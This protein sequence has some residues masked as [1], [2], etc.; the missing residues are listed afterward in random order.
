MSNIS[1]PKIAAWIL[2]RMIDP[3][4]RYSAAG[5]FEERFN[6]IAEERG[7]LRARLFYWSQILILFPSFFNNQIYW[8]AEM[9][10]NYFKIAIRNIVKHKVYSFINIFGLAIGM[11]CCI[12]IILFV[13]EEL[14]FDRYHEN[15][16]QLYRIASQRTQPLD[17][18]PTTRSHYNIAPNLIN[19]FPE[20]EDAVRLIKHNGFVVS[21][22]D[23]RLIINPLYADP[24]LLEVFTFPL[25]RGD[26]KTALQDPNSVVI[27]EE[28][29]ERIFGVKNPMGEILAIHSL[30]S[31]YDL[32]VTG[33]LKNVPYNS[34]FTFNFL[35]PME[36]LRSRYEN[37]RYPSCTTYLLLNENV[38]P[39]EFEKKMP[40][41]VEKYLGER[42]ASAFKYFLQPLTSIHLN[43]E[44]ALEIGQNSDISNSYKLSAVALVVLL[45]ACFNFMN[46]ST[47]RSSQ[48]L[49]EVGVRK[50]VGAARGQI[51]RQFLGE[52]IFLSFIAL[53]FA[54]IL[55]SLFLQFFNSIM[56]RHLTMDFTEN[57]L[58]YAGLASLALIVGFFSGAYPAVFLS[59]F[60]PMDVLKR[61]VKKGTMFGV[62]MRKGLVVFQF[63]A[64]L[65]F[66][67]GTIV[68]FQQLNFISKKDLGFDKS[69][70][71][72]IPVYKDQKFTQRSEWI[73]SEL[74]RNPN[75]LSVI[76]TDDSPGTYG[77]HPTQCSPEGFSDDEFVELNQLIVGEDFFSFFGI[78]IIVGR[79]FSK[80]IAS[81]GDS[82]IILNETA[83]KRLGWTDPIGKQIKSGDSNA[84]RTVIGVVRDFHNASLHKEIRPSIYVYM[85]DWRSC[86]F[87]RVRPNNIQ[88]TIS[89]L[90]KKWLEFPTHLVFKYEFLDDF[91]E[92]S[93]Y[94]DDKKTS[95]VFKFASGLAIFIACLGLF[96]L[97]LFTADQRT[98]EIGIRKVLGGNVVGI[99]LLLSKDFIK[100]VLAAN[101][102]AWP[103]A[104]IV[105]NRW[106]QDFVYRIPIGLW[107]FLFSAVIV[108][109]ISILTVSYQ[110]IKAAI[111]NPV[112][113]L[114]YE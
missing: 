44:V 74:S 18:D 33:I 72:K 79:D 71:I 109:V 112:D 15:A 7:P 20:V 105:M 83:I 14:N 63:A 47:A 23:K 84:A 56:N 30:S 41:F 21:Y 11:A 107:M 1:F 104:Y 76:V 98:K 69:H 9:I 80:Q 37:N 93:L 38:S 64:S 34:H 65:V 31:K 95:Q 96:G 113:S 87:L 78:D 110:T 101:F 35:A 4:V 50:V 12:V 48:R 28:L 42:Y 106:L 61:D 114:R 55:A 8:S 103:V 49:R 17:S 45:I 66:I 13:R 36:H 6:A 94:E 100:L 102:L 82:A 111:A 54:V 24:S 19:D 51:L 75:I 89:F 22:G 77:G 46:L 60:K 59:S 70:I 16:N 58:L 62:F 91:L 57:M 26:K 68:V 99:V 43:S 25:I 40:N 39:E 86:I 29:A 53:L 108:L 88:E 52:A 10:K 81:D 85:P 67:I 92:T 97:A 73:K 5:D 90:E 3:N 32:K 2:E 27:S